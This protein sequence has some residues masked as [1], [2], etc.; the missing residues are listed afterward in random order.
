MSIPITADDIQVKIKLVNSGNILAQATVILFGIWEEHGW[1]IIKSNWTH[2]K[3][4]ENIWIQPPSYQRSGKWTEIVFI[5]NRAIYELVLEKIYD[6]YH[7]AKL[8]TPP[9]QNPTSAATQEIVRD[10]ELDIDE[11]AKQ[12]Q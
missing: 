4:G 5:N 9:D 10:E 11:I 3:F 8:R 12:I 2:L 6:A 7:L 1:K